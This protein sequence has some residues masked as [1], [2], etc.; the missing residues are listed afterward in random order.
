M[1]YI[2]TIVG[3][4]TAHTTKRFGMGC[5]NVTLSTTIRAASM[6]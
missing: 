5:E 1:V 2:G 4:Q 6:V 3:R